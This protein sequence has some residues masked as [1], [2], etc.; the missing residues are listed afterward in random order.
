MSIFNKQFYIIDVCMF[1]Y[2]YLLIIVCMSNIYKVK[3][4]NII[5]ITYISQIFQKELARVK[6]AALSAAN[7][8]PTCIFLILH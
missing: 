8:S 3:Y 2:F 7:L 6:W 1:K 4:L 5:L